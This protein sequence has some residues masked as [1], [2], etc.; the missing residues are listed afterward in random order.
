MKPW[1]AFIKH[2]EAPQK[3]LWK[4]V[5]KIKISAQLSKSFPGF[6]T[7]TMQLIFHSRSCN[8]WKQ[9]LFTIFLSS[10]KSSKK[11]L[12]HHFFMGEFLTAFSEQSRNY[13]IVH[14]R[15][16]LWILK[17]HPNVFANFVNPRIQDVNWKY[18][19]RSEVVFGTSCVHKNL[20]PVP[21]G[22]YA[23]LGIW[24]L[25][26]FVISNAVNLKQLN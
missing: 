3:K 13:F 8:N 7:Y 6:C 18:I 15:Q 17:K 19:R 25:H 5:L 1:K 21:G 23:I 20:C 16:I 4:L 22:K 26:H 12:H 24:R 10:V 9:T 2:S 11:T 14:I